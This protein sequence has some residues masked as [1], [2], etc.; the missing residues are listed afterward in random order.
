MEVRVSKLKCQCSVLE[1]SRRY[2]RR[3][4]SSGLF[5][6]QEAMEWS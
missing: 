6:K 5:V 3:G 4:T 2:V 1:L